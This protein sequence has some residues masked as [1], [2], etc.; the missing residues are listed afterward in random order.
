MFKLVNPKHVRQ[1][2]VLN[3]SLSL[4]E[5]WKQRVC[6]FLFKKTLY[7]IDFRCNLPNDS[8][9]KQVK[10]TEVYILWIFYKKILTSYW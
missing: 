9:Q 2:L 4:S 10:A 8:K 6:F 1:A 5:I 7:A 3:D